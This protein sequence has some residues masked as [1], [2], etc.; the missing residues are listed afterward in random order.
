MSKGKF[1]LLTKVI[2]R[3]IICIIYRHVRLKYVRVGCVRNDIS[4][5]N[6]NYTGIISWKLE[7]N[8]FQLNLSGNPQN[9]IF[10]P[11]AGQWNPV[12]NLLTWFSPRWGLA[13]LH[14]QRALSGPTD[15]FGPR[16][17]GHPVPEQ[18]LQLPKHHLVILPIQC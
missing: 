18:D 2:F 5:T 7:K 8:F 15:T 1:F 10:R 12:L 17:G 16:H 11:S 9:E 3:R 4:D 14:W 6:R 13:Y